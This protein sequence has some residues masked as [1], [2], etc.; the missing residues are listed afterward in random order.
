MWF[1]MARVLSYHVHVNNY[2][3]S[4]RA[5][6]GE[7]LR[8]M[9]LREEHC[10]KSRKEGDLEFD[11]FIHECLDQQENRRIF[12]TVCDFLRTVPFQGYTEAE[13]LLSD[14]PP[15]NP[16]PTHLTALPFRLD[17][18]I[19]GLKKKADIHIFRD[20]ALPM[21]EIDTQL[22]EAGFYA[23]RHPRSRIYTL[24]TESL[25]DAQQIFDIL[26]RYFAREH[27]IRSME[28]ETVRKLM[29]FGDMPGIEP[30]LSKGA[31]QIF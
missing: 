12:N 15:N 3:S 19:E 22:T 23:V 7:V 31:F 10:F 2:G 1:Y 5:R 26:L 29:S 25:S 8:N 17:K 30:A 4:K 20:A 24:Q 21:D 9:N 13:V 28:L 16:N 14:A 18:F 27:G 6:I 11:L